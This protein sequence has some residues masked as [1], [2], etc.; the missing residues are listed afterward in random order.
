MQRRIQLILLGIIVVIT[1]LHYFGI[2][3][4]WYNTLF[5]FDTP[6]H[7]MGGMF[8]G[9]LFVYLF[10][11][12]HDLFKTESVFTFIILGVGFTVLIG[13]LWEF[14]ELFADVVVI[15]RYPLLDTP[16]RIHF[17]TLKDLFNDIVGGA[18]AVSIFARKVFKE[19]ER[20][21]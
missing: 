5:W 11:I 19:D 7:L 15:K 18:I 12:R 8:V 9:T 3:F 1:A 21:F 17:D 14:F 10:R 16:G 2:I 13:V 6:M 4:G 20:N